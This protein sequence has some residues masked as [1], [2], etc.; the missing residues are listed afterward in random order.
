[1]TS[2]KILLVLL[3]LIT[4][5]YAFAERA[6]QLNVMYMN[7]MKPIISLVAGATELNAC[8]FRNQRWNALIQGTSVLQ[9]YSLAG[10]IWGMR[11]GMLS[12][13]ALVNF[14]IMGNRLQRIRKVMANP[15]ADDCRAIGSD[16]DV[17][18][19]LD[20]LARMVGWSPN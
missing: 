16:S 6:N 13:G 18:P 20:R 2:T 11:D 19:A 1:M 3:V 12:R 4:P 7:D 14:E 15:T 5:R 8:G 9:A 10:H 17:L